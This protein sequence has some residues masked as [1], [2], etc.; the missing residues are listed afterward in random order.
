MGAIV[1]PRWQRPNFRHSPSSTAA[2]GPE[3]PVLP[4]VR[5]GGGCALGLGPAPLRTG[6]VLI[7][8]A[9]DLRER[10]WRGYCGAGSSGQGEDSLFGSCPR[11]PPRELSPISAS[12]ISADLRP[13]PRSPPRSRPADLRPISVSRPISDLPRSPPISDLRSSVPISAHRSRPTPSWPSAEGSEIRGRR[14]VTWV[15][16]LGYVAVTDLHHRSPP[17]PIST[18]SPISTDLPRSPTTDLPPISCGTRR[19]RSTRVLQ[20]E[21]LLLRPRT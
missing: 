7:R 11:S 13:R 19:A 18:R 14:H 16:W 6:P 8:G 3:R 9:L 12:P 2:P 21:A 5:P 1:C 17:S 10:P 15:T 20:A 4:V